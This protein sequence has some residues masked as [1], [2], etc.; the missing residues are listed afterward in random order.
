LQEVRGQARFLGVN[1]K[2]IMKTQARLLTAAVLCATGVSALAQPAVIQFTSANYLVNE[3]GGTA[4]ITAEITWGDPFNVYTVNYLT[5]DGTAR[6]GEDYTATNGTL[7]FEWPETNKTFT[8][9]IL[10]DRI[11]EGDEGV[12]LTLSNPGCGG[13]AG[14][15]GVLGAR[16]NALITISDNERLTAVDPSFHGPFVGTYPWGRGSLAIIVEQQDGR[17]VV[18][19]DFTDLDGIPRNGV[20][21]LNADGSVDTT[22]DPGSGVEH[23]LQRGDV[24]AL[25]VQPDGKILLAGLLDTVNGIG[26]TNLARLN[27]DGSLDRSFDAGSWASGLDQYFL[28]LVLQADGKI[29]V[30]GDNNSVAGGNPKFGR[31]HADGSVDAA[32]DPVLRYCGTDSP[33]FVRAVAVQPDG[34]I[35]IGGNFTCVNGTSRTNLARLNP[36][37]S[38]DDTFLPSPPWRLPAMDGTGFLDYGSPTDYTWIYPNSIIVQSDE[39]LLVA[40]GFNTEDGRPLWCAVRLNSNGS[41]DPTFKPERAISRMFAVQPDGKVLVEQ[42]E[43]CTFGCWGPLTRLNPDGSPDRAF[44]GTWAPNAAVLLQTDGNILIGDGNNFFNCDSARNPDCFRQFDGPIR[45]FGIQNRIVQFDSI[46]RL[47]EGHVQL[48]CS[49]NFRATFT[50]EVSANLVDW[51]PLGTLTAS[52]TKLIFTDTNAPSFSRRFYRAVSP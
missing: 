49:S 40:A 42:I 48:T 7:S 14:C 1:V 20:A 4:M 23:H 10:D 12:H 43:H 19:S 24:R 32:F 27:T 29:L 46:G 37:G 52:G 39:K 34:R 15:D 45:L 2:A 36:D 5:Y 35:V 31:L 50:V 11:A 9:A 26:R 47:P 21:R 28:V 51:V 38:L 33:G 13:L 44:L 17:L 41:W 18:G 22:F 6:A 8:V 16:S 25:A 3:A 30:A